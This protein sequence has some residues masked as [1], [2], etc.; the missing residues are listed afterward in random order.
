MSA[1]LYHAYVS[2]L[3]LCQQAY[4]ST[5]V[6]RCQ[7]LIEQLRELFENCLVPTDIPQMYR[8]EYMVCSTLLHP[9]DSI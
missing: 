5:F 1:D 9:A 7:Q 4:V 6:V 3:G 8:C 2:R